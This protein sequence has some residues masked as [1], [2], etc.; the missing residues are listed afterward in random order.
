MEIVYC[1][2]KYLHGK[3]LSPSQNVS[4]VMLFLVSLNRLHYLSPDEVTH[5]VYLST[6]LISRLFKLPSFP[7]LFRQLIEPEHKRHANTF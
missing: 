5:L 7:L 6:N 1:L 3:R 4:S 2:A